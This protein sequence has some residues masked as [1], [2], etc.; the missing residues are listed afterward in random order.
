MTSTSKKIQHL[1]WRAEFGISSKDIQNTPKNVKTAIEQI[2][3]RAKPVYSLSSDFDMPSLSTM[4]N[5]SGKEKKELR[6]KGRQSVREINVEWIKQMA[7]P[8]KGTLREKMAFFWHGH[9]ACELKNPVLATQQINTIK[10]HALGNFKDLVLAITKDAAMILYLNNQQ[11]RKRSP[12]ENFA[13]ELME[14]F[15]IG[16]GNYTENDIKEAARA[17]TGW[18]ANRLT[19]EFQFKKWAHDEENKTFMGKTGNFDGT[20]IIDIILSKK[21]TAR[22]IASKIYT[23]FVNE[24]TKNQKHIEELATVFFDS[25][26]DIEKLMKYLFS[27]DWFYEEEHIG[28]KIKSPVEFLVGMMRTLHL[29]FE[30][31]DGILFTQKALGQILFRPPNVAGWQGGKNWIDN[32]TLL[33][34]LNY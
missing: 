6:K 10:K 29:N 16:R 3:E 21:Q 20:D 7:H 13:R 15:T 27:Q 24:T 1:Y 31:Q 9:F 22:Y 23:F 32:A 8:K 26:Y 2:F 18:S 19:G 25:N 14:L 33:V 4:K 5:M 11:N 28:S 34:R 12:N 17:F 30:S